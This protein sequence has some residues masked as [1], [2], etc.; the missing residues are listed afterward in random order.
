[1]GWDK[2]ANY[3]R[4]RRQMARRYGTHITKRRKKSQGC[5]VATAVYGSY[6]CPEVWTLRRYRDYVL[7]ESVFGRLFI[8]TYYGLS[9]LA[10][11]LFGDKKWFK[12]LLKPA[13]D[14]FVMR[15]KE[16]GIE[17]SA[18]QDRDW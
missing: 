10:V 8:R 14:R 17:D 15:L 12:G 3:R 16:R 11:Q 13:L 4:N 7:A 18:Y 9:P 5:Y 1:M 6:D 2:S